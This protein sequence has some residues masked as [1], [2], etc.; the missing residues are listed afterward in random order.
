MD[1]SIS[2]QPPLRSDSDSDSIARRDMAHAP[3]RLFPQLGAYVYS[4]EENSDSYSDSNTDHESHTQDTLETI[5]RRNMGYAAIFFGAPFRS[6]SEVEDDD[7]EEEEV[8]ISDQDSDECEDETHEHQVVKRLRLQQGDDSPTIIMRRNK[9]YESVLLAGR[10][11]YDDTDDEEEN[12]SYNGGDDGGLSGM[13][14]GSFQE[15]ANDDP[16]GESL[17]TN[18]SSEHD[19][20]CSGE[21]DLFNNEFEVE[22][23]PP[24]RRFTHVENEKTHQHN[25]FLLLPKLHQE[26]IR[27]ES[28]RL[29]GREERKCDACGIL[30]PTRLWRCNECSMTKHSSPMLCPECA[31]QDHINNPHCMFVLCQE[32]SVFRKPLGHEII[33]FKLSI[34]ACHSCHT[35]NPLEGTAGCSTTTKYIYVF[36]ASQSGIFHCTCPEGGSRCRGCGAELICGPVAFDCLPCEP[37]HQSGCTWFTNSLLS[38]I[39]TLRSEGGISANALARAIMEHWL[40]RNSFLVNLE[41]STVSSAHVI[42]KINVHWLEK[43]LAHIITTGVLLEHPSWID[44]G[45]C[46]KLDDRMS[47]VCASCHER[48]AQIHIDG[49]FKMRRM[50]RAKSFRESKLCFFC[51]VEK[52]T[53]DGFRQLDLDNGEEDVDMCADLAGN[54]TGFR[55]GG[56]RQQTSSVGYSQTGILTGVCPHRVPISIIPMETKGEKFF[57][58]HAML[59]FFEG[60]RYPGEVDFYSYDVACRL[61]SYLQIRDHDL[62]VKVEPKLVLGYFHSKSHKCQRWNVGYSRVG[63]GYNDGEQGERLNSL[64]LKYTSFLRYMREEHMIE[65]LEDFLM[66]LTRQANANIDIVL[67]KKLQNSIAHLCEWHTNFVKLCMELEG[68]LSPQGFYLDSEEV[69]QWVEAYTT[70][71]VAN[72]PTVEVTGTKA[73]QEYVWACFEWL[74]LGANQEEAVAALREI[75]QLGEPIDTCLL[76]KKKY[77]QSLVRTY[78]RMTKKKGKVSE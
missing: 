45:V 19:S 73:E 9:Q 58:P 21:V 33:T 16:I 44:E 35:A 25:L 28:L 66:C 15:E 78:E 49:F 76:D 72:S 31:V 32:E 4:S 40:S 67:S 64:M 34:G 26:R 27:L 68:R 59:H 42:P 55:A 13:E 3:A 62:N 38:F 52:D 54:Q 24:R 74:Q 41:G 29:A 71:P 14:N 46:F 75:N 30:N 7:E 77:L 23:S 57:M 43:K 36:V 48:C 5:T 47:S 22:F 8:S 63:S 2:P 50:R 70:R 61:K 56:G 10:L 6:S 51:N 39:R 20:I 37:V 65:A 11:S 1:R 18:S 17:Q 12:I 60:D 53:V 69:Q